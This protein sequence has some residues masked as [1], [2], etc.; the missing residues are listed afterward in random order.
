MIM[1]AGLRKNVLRIWRN[2]ASENFK[3]LHGSSWDT[4]INCMEAFLGKLIVKAKR[5][6]M[7]NVSLFPS[8]INGLFDKT[9]I[10]QRNNN[11]CQLID[12]SF[13]PFF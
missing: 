3:K 10:D 13:R 11:V 1:A 9:F 7:K 8:R 5:D 6:H 4:V 2:S 12:A